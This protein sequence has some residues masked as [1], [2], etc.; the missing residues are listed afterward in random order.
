[1]IADSP[2]ST[3][4]NNAS[5]FE[6]NRT[7]FGRCTDSGRRVVLLGSLLIVVLVV[8]ALAAQSASAAPLFGAKT[9]L[10]T[11]PDPR[12]V[13]TADFNNDGM[14]DVLVNALTEDAIRVLLN[15]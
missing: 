8:S 1:M 12:S 3:R 6:P 5:D 14:V 4:R 7:V 13:T 10:T 2:S 9:D 11:G 15:I